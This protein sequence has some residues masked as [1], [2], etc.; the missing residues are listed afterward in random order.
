MLTGRVA[1]SDSGS[2]D[3]SQITDGHGGYPFS[4]AQKNW[5]GLQSKCKVAMDF[6]LLSFFA[7]CSGTP[8]TDFRFLSLLAGVAPDAGTSSLVVAAA[9]ADFGAA[10]SVSSASPFPSAWAGS[11]L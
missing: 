6:F 8:P 1:R 7:L 10:A 9:S 5:P 4:L 11:S 2:M 3:S